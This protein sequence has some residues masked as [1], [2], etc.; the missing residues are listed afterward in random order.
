M[1][2]SGEK[3]NVDQLRKCRYEL[4]PEYLNLQYELFR[5]GPVLWES[6]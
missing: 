3:L 6:K 4:R 2:V 1:F 5:A